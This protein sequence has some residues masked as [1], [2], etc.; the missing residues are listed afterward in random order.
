MWSGEWYP[1]AREIC[2]CFEVVEFPQRSVEGGEDER[3]CRE[4]ESLERSRE[5]YATREIHSSFVKR[6]SLSY[7]ALSLW[8]EHRTGVIRLESRLAP[9]PEQQSRLRVYE[10]SLFKLLLQK[11]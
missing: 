11:D 8:R 9:W 2:G 7:T 3:E 6:V 10:P 5:G 4:V 1:R